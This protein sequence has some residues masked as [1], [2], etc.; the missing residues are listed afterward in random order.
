MFM[1]FTMIM[2]VSFIGWEM[3]KVMPALLK[4]WMTAIFTSKHLYLAEHQPYEPLQEDGTQVFHRPVM[5]LVHTMPERLRIRDTDNG[6]ELKEQIAN[7]EALHEAFRRG[8]I[9]EIYKN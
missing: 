4:S 9:R 5:H 6:T 1:S 2:I 8:A 7:L 3:L